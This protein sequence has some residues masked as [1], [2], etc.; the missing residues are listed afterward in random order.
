MFQK[1]DRG[2]LGGLG[3]RLWVKKGVVSRC[4][5]TWGRSRGRVAGCEDPASVLRRCVWVWAASRC[6]Q[7]GCW[8]DW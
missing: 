8:I 7:C 3:L 4:V 6:T 2:L 5:C 1:R